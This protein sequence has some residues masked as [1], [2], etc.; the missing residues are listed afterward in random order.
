MR[1]AM[2]PACRSRRCRIAPTDAHDDARR[3]ARRGYQS[4]AARVASAW[5]SCHRAADGG[6]RRSANGQ[7]NDPGGAMTD[8]LR[9]WWNGLSRRE[10]WL[11]GVAGVLACGVLIRS[12]EHTSELQSL[13]RISYAVF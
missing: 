7:Y 2:R 3:A 8:K 11:V 12:E 10:R 13:M 1:W 9:N 5:L 4:G 6:Q